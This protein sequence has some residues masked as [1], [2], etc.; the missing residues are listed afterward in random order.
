M[1]VL[2]EY[3]TLLLLVCFLLRFILFVFFGL[4]LLIYL[5][6]K[7]G[8]IVGKNVSANLGN[9]YFLLFTFSFFSTI[10]RKNIIFLAVQATLALFG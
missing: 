9:I 10:S 6:K 2:K 7:W 3:E 1:L 4:N 8:S 5:L